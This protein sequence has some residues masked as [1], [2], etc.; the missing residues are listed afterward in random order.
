MAIG[1]HS[2][3][4]LSLAEAAALISDGS[5]IALGGLS[6]HGA[7]MSLVREL[8]RRRVRGLTLITAA[9]T[10]LQVDLLV[11]GGCVA[12]IVS[13]FVAFEDLGLAPNFRRAVESGQVKLEEIGEAFLAFGLKAGASGAPFY[14]LPSVLAGSSCVRENPLYRFTHD[15]FTDREVL[16]VPALRPD[17][18]LLHAQAADPRGNL[19]QTAAYMDP[20]LARASRQVL[21]TCD[22]VLNDA[23]AREPR[24]VTVPSLLVRGVVPLAG[25]ARPGSSP[26]RYD[27]DRTEI[28]R[29]VSQTKTDSGRQDFLASLGAAGAGE[30][31]YLD[32]LGPAPAPPGPPPAPRNDLNAPPSK[33]ELLAT[34]IARSVT[35]GMF[36]AAGTGC[37]EVAAGLRLAQ[38]THAPKLRFTLGGTV[39]FNPSLDY[40]PAS[41]NSAEALA[42]AEAQIALEDLF[43]LEMAGAFDMMFVSALQIDAYGNLNLARLGPRDRPVFRGPGTVG[44]EFAPCTRQIVAFFRNHS[45]QSFVERVDF[46]SGFGYGEGP[47]SRHALGLEENGGPMRVVT[48]LAVMGFCPETKR[49]RLES[50]H[51]GVTADEVRA[52]T[53]FDLIVPERLAVTQPPTPAE[54]ELLRTK[55]DRGGLLANLIR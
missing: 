34:L 42:G 49:M 16:C 45:R 39:A 50:V 13:P 40:L 5:T 25:A 12:R 47:G 24:D 21:A 28:R 33:A 7:P 30:T 8:V 17:W 14:A 53:G 48:N 26:G 29:Y 15:P 27:A 46:V 35:D 11:A 3:K 2:G 31:A 51:P 32:R 52:Q 10:G 23:A 38:L 20:L 22:E 55:I 54:L 4:I 43:D 41:L 37:W 18:T 9:V 19:Y 6:Y 44:L 36:T 1:S